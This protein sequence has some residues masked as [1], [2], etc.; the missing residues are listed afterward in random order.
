[1][2]PLPA[3][4]LILSIPL[5]ATGGVVVPS[6]CGLPGVGVV[7]LEIGPDWDGVGVLECLEERREDE[8]SL[9][10]V[11]G[12]NHERGREEET[13][14]QQWTDGERPVCWMCARAGAHSYSQFEHVHCNCRRRQLTLSQFPRHVGISAQPGMRQEIS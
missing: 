11:R 1:M 14:S 7:L 3:V 6:G 2:N 5:L 4:T 9:I 12:G 13:T 8:E 10:S